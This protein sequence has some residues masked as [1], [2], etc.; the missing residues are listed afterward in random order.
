MYRVLLTVF[1]VTV[2]FLQPT[3]EVLAFTKANEFVRTANYFLLSGQRLDDAVG[4]LATFDLIVIPVEAQVYNESFFETI[5]EHNPDI[6]IL[7]YIP[8]V[9]WNDL[10]W[11][12]SLHQSLYSQIDDDWW[13]TDS[14]SDQV[15][16]W[17]NTRALNLNSGWGEFLPE[18]VEDEV[19]STNLWDGIFYDEVQDSISW[20]GDVDVDQNGSRDS[21][22]HADDL[23]EDAYEQLFE[24]TRELINDEYVMITNGSS[25]NRFAPFVNGRMFETFPSSD[26]TLAE[27]ESMT[28]EYLDLEQ[29]VGYPSIQILNVN[30]ENTGVD[31]D[32]QKI[33]FGITTTLLGDG[34]FSYDHGTEDHAQLWTYDEYDVYLG[35]PKTELQNTLDPQNSSIESGVWERDFEKGKVI[36]NATSS[37]QNVVLEGELEKIHGN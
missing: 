4:T 31:D 13:L 15:S 10:Y 12:D 36:V 17:P 5:R 6:V 9:S 26:N 19:L 3:K 18:W 20:L 11:N 16:V 8:T 33:R 37:K 27:W 30:S 35:A 23:W 25:N 1:F 32:Y 14:D 2:I 21:G 22:S 24:E 7:P 34:Y 28:K 29:D